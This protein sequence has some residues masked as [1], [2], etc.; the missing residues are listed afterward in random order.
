MDQIHPHQ[1]YHSLFPGIAWKFLGTFRSLPDFVGSHVV[2][3]LHAA[4]GVH[5]PGFFS[6]LAKV[7]GEAESLRLPQTK[8][9]FDA[10]FL[11]DHVREEQGRWPLV[12]LCATPAMIASVTTDLVGTIGL[13]EGN[14]VYV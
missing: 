12:L 4:S 9:V 8:A 13:P 14:L 10:A 5:E 1:D 7:S 6:G 3:A 11:K 2:E